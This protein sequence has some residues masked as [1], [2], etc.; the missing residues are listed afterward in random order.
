MVYR[1]IIQ[2]SKLNMM[3]YYFQFAGPP[4][5]ERQVRIAN[6]NCLIYHFYL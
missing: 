2:L 5:M 4:S 3:F 1:Q 6:G